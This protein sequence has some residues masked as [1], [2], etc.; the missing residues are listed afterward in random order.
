M[1]LYMTTTA[2][3]MVN[4]APSDPPEL[5][6]CDPADASCDPNA[7]QLYLQVLPEKC[8]VP[9]GTHAQL[10]P[11]ALMALI[12]YS[13]VYPLMVTALLVKNKK[14]IMGD[15]IIKVRFV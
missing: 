12:V 10:L 14:Q 6:E 11:F 1:Y 4:C 7:L 9:G 15:Q 2:L 8:Y 13:V 3:D 5:V